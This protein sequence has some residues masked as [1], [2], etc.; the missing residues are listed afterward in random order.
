MQ[1]SKLVRK[2]ATFPSLG[3]RRSAPFGALW[4]VSNELSCAK[5][6]NLAPCF[7]TEIAP[8][9]C[10]TVKM[11]RQTTKVYGLE[12]TCLGLARERVEHGPVGSE[13]PTQPNEAYVCLDPLLHQHSMWCEVWS[14]QKVKW[15]VMMNV[16]RMAFVFPRHTKRCSSAEFHRPL[17]CGLRSQKAGFVLLPFRAESCGKTT[18]ASTKMGVVFLDAFR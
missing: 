3:H 4:P 1:H 16:L 5:L 9:H 13:W 11:Q 10:H 15:D 14:K 8:G 2:L 17:E 18:H 6:V 7:P 12:L